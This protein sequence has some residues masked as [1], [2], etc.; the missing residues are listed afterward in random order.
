MV[1]NDEETA[2]RE[3]ARILVVEDE[4]DQQELL[5]YN[6]VREGYEVACVDDGAEA[7]EQVDDQLPDLIV[8]DLMLPGLDGL[9]V[10]RRLRRRPETA[11]VPIVMLTAKGEDS[12]VVAG[13]ELGA[14]DYVTKPYSP[15]VLLARVKAVLRARGRTAASPAETEKE[16]VIRHKDLVIRPDRF[17]VEVAE[18]PVNL[19]GTE[20]RILALLAGKPG[21][22]FTRAQ[23]IRG[24]HG[25]NCAVTDRSVDV[26][27]F[28][29][30][31]KL[32][33]RGRLIEAVRGVGYRFRDTESE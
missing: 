13:L 28:W 1:A 6:L 17:E 9:E 12:D 11:A 33:G 21:R 7:L 5:R 20:F 8:L 25:E 27:I 15:R 19:S 16:K 24:V 4:P 26:H 2:A 30:R 29:L 10:C 3:Q 32:G 31:N 14:D 18:K 23:I 22:V